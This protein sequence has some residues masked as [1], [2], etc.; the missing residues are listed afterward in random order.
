MDLSSPSCH[1]RMRH[2]ANVSNIRAKFGQCSGQIRAE[3]GLR[4]RRYHPPFF[5]CFARRFCR[6]TCIGSQVSLPRYWDR[7]AERN[8]QGWR[9][10]GHGLWFEQELRV[11]P[12]KTTKKE[13]NR[14]HTPML[15]V[16]C[17]EIWNVRWNLIIIS[18]NLPTG[19]TAITW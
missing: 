17:P 3:F 16:V 10:F 7:D 2:F 11:P 19:T 6:V 13:R 12:P 15:L 14:S 9:G 4:F 1:R 18:Y 5:V 8:V